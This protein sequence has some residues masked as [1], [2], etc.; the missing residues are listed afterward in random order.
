MSIGVRVFLE[1]VGLELIQTRKDLGWTQK[2][3]AD[4]L[5]VTEQQVQKLEA[6]RYAGARLNTLIRV[7]R[8]LDQ[9]LDE[10]HE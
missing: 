8:A 2:R 9:T 5:G 7:A 1:H 4:R 3:L 10:V 6:S